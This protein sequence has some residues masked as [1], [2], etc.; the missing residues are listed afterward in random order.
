MA[1]LKDL[2][3]KCVSVQKPVGV[4]PPGFLFIP[5]LPVSEKPAITIKKGK[6]S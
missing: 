3:S 4:L 2:V 6:K 1:S 5:L